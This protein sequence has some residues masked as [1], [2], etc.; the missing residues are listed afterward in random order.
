MLTERVNETNLNPV[1]IGTPHGPH[2]SSL[3]GHIAT[4]RSGRLLP[5]L[6]HAVWMSVFSWPMPSRE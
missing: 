5:Q 6:K 1:I 3:T 2:D 4:T